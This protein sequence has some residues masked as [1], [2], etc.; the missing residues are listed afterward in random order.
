MCFI[1]TAA[2]RASSQIIASLYIFER[3]SYELIIP[4]KFL[5]GRWVCKPTDLIAAGIAKQLTPRM[6]IDRTA[7]P[8]TLYTLPMLVQCWASV[9]DVGLTL[10]QHWVNVS[11]E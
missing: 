9:S 8:Q 6:C 7:F 2:L 5:A 4:P 1:P 11:F 3:R 10:K